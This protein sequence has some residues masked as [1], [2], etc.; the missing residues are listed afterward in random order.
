M[1]MLYYVL[2]RS[3][4]MVMFDGKCYDS[5][6]D[7]ANMLQIPLSSLLNYKHI[8][9]NDDKA[10][11]ENCNISGINY[12]NEDGVLFEDARSLCK[13]YDIPY[14]VFKNKY[15]GES[16][17]KDILIY[18][19]SIK[20]LLD[21]T[22]CNKLID[23]QHKLKMSRE[24]LKSLVDVI[25]NEKCFRVDMLSVIMQQPVETIQGT[26]IV[27]NGKK[28]N[29]LTEL[30]EDY[31]IKYDTFVHR[32]KR[33][34][35]IEEALKPVSETRQIIYNGVEYEGI[36]DFAASI[37]LSEYT[38]RKRLKAGMSIEEIVSIG[39]TPKS[40]KTKFIF[41]G[42][43]YSSYKQLAKDY[44]MSY[45]TLLYRLRLGMTLEKA[46]S[47]N[48]RK[49]KGNEFSYN[50]ITYYSYKEFCKINKLSYKKF[51]YYLRTGHSIKECMTSCLLE[52]N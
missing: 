47:R 39:K 11:I 48:T 2:E 1:M 3:D 6:K 35:S 10:I 23:V 37:G 29:S 41:R 18:C 34:Y 26:F 5:L 7:V 4:A 19:L 50:G 24:Q 33:G 49:G 45:V 12:V 46:V 25:D 9:K 8:Y 15:N 40:L 51:M 13:Y 16:S 30:C 38:V 28:Y 22:G 31:G 17:V 43:S 44:S 21:Y 52:E 27:I 42:K 36:K 32:R 20:E 14:K